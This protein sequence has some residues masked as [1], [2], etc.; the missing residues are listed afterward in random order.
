ML[1][2]KHYY[3]LLSLHRYFLAHLDTWCMQSHAGSGLSAPPRVM[4][5]VSSSAGV[6]GQGRCVW[7][8]PVL[9]ARGFSPAHHMCAPVPGL[10]FEKCLLL[11][12]QPQNVQ[13]PSRIRASVS[14][15]SLSTWAHLS[16]ELGCRA[17]W[18][19]G[20]VTFLQTI[21][22]VWL[23]L[24]RLGGTRG[25]CLPWMGLRCGQGEG[26]WHTIC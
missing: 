22:F 18:S 8:T 4:W 12:S 10:D 16:L 17:F 23:W 3:E 7:P 19:Q 6:S 11:C 9:G 13:A 26:C 1:N 2:W 15:H 21:G 24:P 5:S 25:L 14:P 20:S